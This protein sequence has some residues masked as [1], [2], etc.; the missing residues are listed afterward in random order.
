MLIKLDSLLVQPGVL[1][2]N[3]EEDASDVEK[4]KNHVTEFIRNIPTRQKR[5]SKI[6]RKVS[7]SLENCY[8]SIREETD[9]L[10]ESFLVS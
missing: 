1:V 10:E 9:K 2:E 5:I 4:E 8:S 7:F 6:N 3:E